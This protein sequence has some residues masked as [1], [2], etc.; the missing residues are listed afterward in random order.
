MKTINLNTKYSPEDQ[1]NYR[2]SQISK[3]KIILMKKYN[4]NNL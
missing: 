3:L 1:T 4:I 2:L